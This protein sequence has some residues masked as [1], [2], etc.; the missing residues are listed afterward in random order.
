MPWKDSCLS[1]TA[2]Q[3]VLATCKF[4]TQGREYVME[5]KGV[6]LSARRLEFSSLYLQPNQNAIECNGKAFRLPLNLRK[7]PSDILTPLQSKTNLTRLP[8]QGNPSS[9][10]R[11]ERGLGFQAR[12]QKVDTERAKLP[13]GT[14]RS[15]REKAAARSLPQGW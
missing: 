11:P 12:H 15:P 7:P 13:L 14:L 10:P 3:L 2:M 6:T 9:L 5:Q 8:Y 1:E 4:T